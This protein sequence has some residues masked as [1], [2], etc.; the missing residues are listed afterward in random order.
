MNENFKKILKYA[1]NNDIPSI[2]Y[3]EVARQLEIKN[4][5]TIIYYLKKIESEG[6]LYYD[7]KT[8]TK[9]PAKRKAFAVDNFFNIP[10]LGAANCGLATELAE[11]KIQGFVKISQKSLNVSTPDNLMAIKAIGNS[12]NKADIKGDSIDEGDYVIVDCSKKNPNNGEYVLSIIDSAANFKRFYKD[13]Q[14]KEIR[15]VSESTSD[16][17]PI[18]LHED[19]INDSGY[20][21]NGVVV[22]VIKN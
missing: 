15:L 2:G 7:P 9:K 10:V 1:K 4:P 17:P 3:R 12:L 18:V 22:R 11:Q 16:I 14:K 19:D 8:K 5:Q 20:M 21:V 6:W 13:D